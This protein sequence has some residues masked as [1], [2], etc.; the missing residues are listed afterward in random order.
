MKKWNKQQ[1]LNFPVIHLGETEK[2]WK[3][4]VTDSW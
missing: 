4:R 2:N 1:L 3:G